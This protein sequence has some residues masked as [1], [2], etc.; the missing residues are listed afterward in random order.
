V[1]EDPLE[2]AGGEDTDDEGGEDEGAEEIVG[3]PLA[4][5][6]GS[7][8]EGTALLL[9]PPQADNKRPLTTI[10]ASIQ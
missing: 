2:V 4:V 7:S 5:W 1:G 8:E 3:A 6:A 9:S 10:K